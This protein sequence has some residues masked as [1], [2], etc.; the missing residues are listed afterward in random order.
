[1][2]FDF[3]IILHTAFGKKPKQQGDGG[4][5]LVCPTGS[6]EENRYVQNGIVAWGVQCHQAIPAVYAN[7]AVARMFIDD[8]ME[9]I[10]LSLNYLDVR[11]DI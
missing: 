4:A 1:M 8:Q 9:A 11:N 5:P 7:V 6:P 10:G 3:S 2:V